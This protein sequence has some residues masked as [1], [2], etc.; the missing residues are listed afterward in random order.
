MMVVLVAGRRK[1]DGNGNTQ[2][3]AQSQRGRMQYAPT[4]A[5]ISVIGVLH[6]CHCRA[7]CM[8]PNG[9]NMMAVRVVERRK[10]DGDACGGTVKI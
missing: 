5:A 7:H 2:A 3:A 1:Y 4:E 9:Q 6:G 10:C 8:R